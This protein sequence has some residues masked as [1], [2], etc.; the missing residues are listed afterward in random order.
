MRLA[1]ALGGVNHD[2]LFHD[3]VIDGGG[4]RLH[5]EHVGATDGLVKATV[6]FPIGKFTQIGFDEVHTE[7]NSNIAGELGMGTTRRQY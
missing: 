1:R 7:V 2:E 3:R 5:D 6:H 4:V